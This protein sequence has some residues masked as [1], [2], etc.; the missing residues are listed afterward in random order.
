MHLLAD[1]SC[2]QCF[3]FTDNE[4]YHTMWSAIQ[5]SG[6]PMVLTVEGNPTDSI[7]TNG[8]YG[9]AKRVGHDISP[10]WTSMT[11]LVDIGR[12]LGG[13]LFIVRL[14]MF[15]LVVTCRCES[16]DVRTQLNGS[17]LCKSCFYPYLW[18]RTPVRA[19]A[20]RLVEW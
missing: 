13:T 17:D 9:N 10:H 11:S 20:G 16:L 2:S 3:N 8:G 1:D 12:V 18:N 5:A 19:F 14:D 4:L 7:I 15:P 6:R